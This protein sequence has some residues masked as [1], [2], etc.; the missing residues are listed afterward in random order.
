MLH[1]LTSPLDM[2]GR[3]KGEL[4]TPALVVDLD[5]MQRNIQLMADF[6]GDGPVRLRPH[7]KTHKTPQIA[8]LQIQAGAVGVTC[9]KVGEAEAMVDGGV[10]DVLIANQIVG[11][12]KIARLMD[13]A[14]RARVM[15]AVDNAD[16][17]ADLSRAAVAAG[18]TLGALVEINHGM[19]RCGTEPGQPTLDLARIVADAPGLRFMGLQAYEGHVVMLPDFEARKAAVEQALAIAMDSKALIEADGL[20]VPVFSG[21]GTG[22]YAITGRYPGVTELQAG[23]Y[24]TMDVGYKRIGMPFECALT[25]LTT[26]VSRPRDGVMVGDSGLKVITPEFGMP[27]IVGLPGAKVIYLS[28]EHTKIEVSEPLPQVKV[29]DKIELIPSHGCTTFNLHDWVY[30]TRNDVVEHAWRVTARGRS[31]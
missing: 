2:V 15:V 29:G 25:V 27:D 31:Q 22:S 8:L 9:Q 13:L 19:N 18:V 20:P 14:Q 17:V 11:P 30:M 16:N 10:E 26:I 3:S 21:G 24:V 12:V 6:L 5:A 28:E 1:S 4:D 7:M 23:S